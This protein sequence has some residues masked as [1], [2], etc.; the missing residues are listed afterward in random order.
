ML[1]TYV[2]IPGVYID[3]DRDI[4]ICSDHVEAEIVEKTEGQV[5]L[6]LKNTTP[7]DAKVTVLAEHGKSVRKLGHLYYGRMEKI[8]VLS[9]E[10]KLVVVTASK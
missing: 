2:E 4:S 10:S 3:L 9:G 7:Y 5:V 1:L 8:L 6:S